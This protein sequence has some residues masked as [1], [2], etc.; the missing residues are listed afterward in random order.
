MIHYTTVLSNIFETDKKHNALLQGAKMD[1]ERLRKEIGEK[2]KNV[3][4]DEA[5]SYFETLIFSLS[6]DEFL[7]IISEIGT[8]PESFQHD[9]S[10]EKLYAKVADIVLAK[11]LQELGLSSN[12]IKTRANCA[13]VIAKSQY[14]SYSL[15]GDAKAFRLSRTAKNQKDF[16]VQSMVHWKEDN[17]FAVLV[18]PLFQYP[19]S[20]SQIYTQALDGNI[21]LFSWEHLSFLIENNITETE[22]FSLKRIWNLSQEISSFYTRAEKQIIF[23]EKQNDIFCNYTDL[24]RKKF[25]KY[26]TKSKDLIISR[27]LEGIQYYKDAISQIE[28]Y[29][30]KK[31]I[32]ELIKSQKINEKI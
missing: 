18:C 32:S 7:P 4:F 20:H 22:S 8:I 24:S 12:V 16:K 9:S 19:R 5:G 3:T 28:K 23:L 1:F 11:A 13:D 21:L 2:L 29:S 26:L 14:H 31:A 30:R 10:E 27:G 6:R 17:D 15:V 25:D